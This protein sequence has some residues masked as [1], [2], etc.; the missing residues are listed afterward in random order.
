[1]WHL[2]FLRASCPP[3]PD[4]LDGVSPGGG[5]QEW[6]AVIDV[7]HKNSPTAFIAR[8]GIGYSTHFLR[9]TRAG[10]PR[11]DPVLSECPLRRTLRPDHSGDRRSAALAQSAKALCCQ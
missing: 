5:Q 8:W 10:H 11:R 9:Q 6:V 7:R 2:L 4:A 3:P 1:M